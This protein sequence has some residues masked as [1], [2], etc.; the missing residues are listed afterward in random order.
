MSE[1]FVVVPEIRPMPIP[2]QF[3]DDMRAIADI[4]LHEISALGAVLDSES[5]LIDDEQLQGLISEAIS[6]E[7]GAKA[8]SPRPHKHRRKPS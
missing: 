2:Q 5:G 3:I 8:V 1:R 6:D 4:P 7:A